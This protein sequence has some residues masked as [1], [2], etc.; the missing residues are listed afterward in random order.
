[1][2]IKAAKTKGA[3]I[4][5]FSPV[6]QAA[7]LQITRSCK[8]FRPEE[9]EIA[10]E[11][12]GEAARDGEKSHYTVLVAELEGGAVGWS[13]H[14]RVPLTDATFDLYWIAVAPSVQS[15]GI[16][17]TLLH[18]VESIVLSSGGRWVLAETSS[19][20]LYEATRNFYERCGYRVLSQ[21]A[22]FYRSGDGKVTFGK[23]LD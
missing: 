7:L 13:C 9:V 18:E 11:V 22:D 16:G 17:R 20:A 12:L 2:S 21:I 10:A 23:R 8:V 6:D 5:P 19:I 3:R 15:R 1:M 4:R 14:G